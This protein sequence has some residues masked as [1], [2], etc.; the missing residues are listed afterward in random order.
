MG[1]CQRRTLECRSESLLYFLSFSAAA[2]ARLF[3]YTFTPTAPPMA[4][5]AT[6]AMTPPISAGDGPDDDPDDGWAADKHAAR[7][8]SSDA[9]DV[10]HCTGAHV[11][12]HTS[13]REEHRTTVQTIRNDHSCMD[14][15]LTYLAG[16]C[17]TVASGR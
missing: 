11:I 13:R 15:T 5:T 16:A 14:I 4:T 10:R 17:A 2:L 3:E 1:H 8:G 9:Q 6:A 12:G 7:M